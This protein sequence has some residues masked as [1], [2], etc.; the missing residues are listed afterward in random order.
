MI[1]MLFRFKRKKI[2]IT[3]IDIHLIKTQNSKITIQNWSQ[4]SLIN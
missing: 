4:Q 1:T 3:K 2:K